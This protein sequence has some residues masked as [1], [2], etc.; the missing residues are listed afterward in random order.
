MKDKLMY[1][2]GCVAGLA[3][4]YVW[5]VTALGKPLWFPFGN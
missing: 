1:V 4:I 3:M 5:T 2:L